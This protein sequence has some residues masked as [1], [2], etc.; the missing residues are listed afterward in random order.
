M[1]KAKLF[2]VE[3]VNYHSIRELADA[4]VLNYRTVTNRMSRGGQ[5]PEEAVGLSQPHSKHKKAL[6]VHGVTYPSVASAAREYGIAP[7]LLYGRLKSG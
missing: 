7:A 3:N 5:S 6:T 4:Y 1:A 2:T